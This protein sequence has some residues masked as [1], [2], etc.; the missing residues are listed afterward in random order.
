LIEAMAG[1]A[2]ASLAQAL[3]GAS[4]REENGTL[5]LEVPQDWLGFAQT[6]QDEYQELARKASGRPL[7]V[8][9][10]AGAAAPPPPP[11]EA[12]QQRQRRMKEASAEPAVQEALDL[13]RGRVVDVREG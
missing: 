1:Q 6:H 8:K 12:D 13:F 2:R 10:V 4:A 9:V 11:S 5:T 7:K 3:R